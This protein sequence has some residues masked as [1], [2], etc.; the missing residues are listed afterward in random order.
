MISRT[1]VGKVVKNGEFD[2]G[3]VDDFDFRYAV[4]DPSQLSLRFLTK[5]R[6]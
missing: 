1:S 6:G 4:G 5:L 2:I 3:A